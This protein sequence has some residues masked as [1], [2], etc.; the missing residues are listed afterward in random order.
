MSNQARVSELPANTMHD[1]VVG[2]Y[3]HQLTGDSGS[4]ATLGD[5]KSRV[6]G[7]GP[8][9]GYFFPVGKSKGYVNLKGYWEFA[10]QTVP[11]DLTC[12]HRWRCRS[13]ETSGF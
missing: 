11:R 12:G 3:F 5:F 2:Y 9:A 13:N 10:A 4:G 8:Q 6:A 1:I 7:I